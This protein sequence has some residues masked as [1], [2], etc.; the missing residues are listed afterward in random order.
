[1][2]PKPEFSRAVRVDTIGAEPR[3]IEIAAE[4]E[5]REALA[6]RFGLV[7]VDRLSAGAALSRNGQTIV[8][9]GRMKAEVT[10]SC[11]ATAAP[12]EAKLDEPFRIE[13]RPQ[14]DP[15]AADE[16]IELSESEMDVVFYDSAS[17]DLG[18]AVAETLSLSLD[19]YPRAPGAEEILKAAGVKGE[20][21]AG[22]F[23][24]LAAL[25]D[26]LGK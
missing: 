20:E 24:A 13:F 10:Q 3:A 8:A 19:P 26:K 25:K 21:E 16:E 5:E 22:P 15:A 4:P 11:V 14:P 6:R 17:I 9:E 2:I 18:E 1:M 23:A 7:A 12:L